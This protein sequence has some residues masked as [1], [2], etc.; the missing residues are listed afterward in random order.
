MLLMVDLIELAHNSDQRHVVVI[1]FAN[2]SFWLQSL[3]M[4]GHSQDHQL[5]DYFRSQ[6]DTEQ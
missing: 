3:P 6:L 1:L 4:E 2:D 5:H